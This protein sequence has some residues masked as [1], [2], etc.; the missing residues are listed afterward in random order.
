LSWR[1]TITYGAIGPLWFSKGEDHVAQRAEAMK[2]HGSGDT[3]GFY[4]GSGRWSAQ[5]P[6]YDLVDWMEEH[7]EHVALKPGK[8]ASGRA[9]MRIQVCKGSNP[10]LGFLEA[11]FIA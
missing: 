4:P 1:N 7:D 3:S 5:N 11:P 9:S 2:Q 10:L 8:V 6:T